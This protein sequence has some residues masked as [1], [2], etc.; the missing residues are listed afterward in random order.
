MDKK[1]KKGTQEGDRQSHMEA[2]SGQNPPTPTG[3]IEG[4]VVYRKEGSKIV[5]V[6]LA[7]D[8]IEAPVSELFSQ[9]TNLTES[10]ATPSLSR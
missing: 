3:K 4:D 9:F 8:Q 7:T 6:S 2:E 5:P 10:S 1:K